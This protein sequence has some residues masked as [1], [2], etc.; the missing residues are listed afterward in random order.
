MSFADNRAASNVVKSD[1]YKQGD[2]LNYK[3]TGTNGRNLDITLL[4]CQNQGY[5]KY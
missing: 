1:P 2:T 4:D 5:Y 3:L